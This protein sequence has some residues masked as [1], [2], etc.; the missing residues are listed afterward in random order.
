MV[1]TRWSRRVFSATVA[2]VVRPSD[3]QPALGL[4]IRQLRKERTLTQEDLA[5]A[6]GITVTA[7]VRIETSKANPTWATVRKIAVGL[8]VSVG[9]IA[10][11]ADRLADSKEQ[12]PTPS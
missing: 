2:S 11:L 7:L 1:F 4:A 8:A 5:H 3:P 9:Q 12:P 6:A 10:D